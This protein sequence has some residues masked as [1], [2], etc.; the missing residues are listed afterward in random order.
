MPWKNLQ[1]MPQFKWLRQRLKDDQGGVLEIDENFVYPI[2][3]LE[4]PISNLTT[5]KRGA[6][7]FPFWKSTYRNNESQGVDFDT[8]DYVA[9]ISNNSSYVG[10]Q[11]N[12]NVGYQKSMRKFKDRSRV[13]QDIDFSRV[14]LRVIAGLRPL[15]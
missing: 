11:I 5:I 6:Q 13:E 3:R 12:V 10:Y 7:G 1:V 2:L 9:L 14:F 15:F 8:E 4:Y